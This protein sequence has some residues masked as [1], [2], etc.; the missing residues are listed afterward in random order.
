M[1]ARQPIGIG[2]TITV[3]ALA[4]VFGFA[5]VENVFLRIA[6]QINAGTLGQLPE[7][8]VA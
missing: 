6:H 5:D 1:P 3:Q 8:I 2:H 4:E 7:E